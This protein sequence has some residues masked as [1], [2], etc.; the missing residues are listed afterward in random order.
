MASQ[1]YVRKG[2][3]NRLNANWHV[4]GVLDFER[5]RI[6]LPRR[7]TLGLPPLVILLSYIREVGFG[8]VVELKDFIFDNSLISVFVEQWRLETHTFH[9]L[10]GVASIT[11]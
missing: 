3:I 5:P 9:L 7:V 4:A 8:H 2:D 10:W 1:Q 6:L 11:L